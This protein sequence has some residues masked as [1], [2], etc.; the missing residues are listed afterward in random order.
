MV[1]HRLPVGDQP[2]ATTGLLPHE[3]AVMIEPIPACVTTT[4]ESRI[5][6][7]RS[8]KSRKSYVREALAGTIADEPC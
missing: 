7:T 8:S 5:S 4:R 2:A 1:V 3:S 6:R